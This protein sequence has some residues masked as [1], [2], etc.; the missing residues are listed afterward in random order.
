MT[1]HF[2]SKKKALKDSPSLLKRK[3]S[4][5]ALMVA[6][7]LMSFVL[8]IILG[9]ST[10]VQVNSKIASS[11]KNL[12]TAKQN[13]LFALNLAIGDLQNEMGPD[14][15]ISATASILDEFPETEA[16]DGVNNPYWTGAWNSNDSLGGNLVNQVVSKN[17]AF[18]DGKPSHFRR[19]LISS[20]I[21]DTSMSP[22]DSIA[23]AKNFN[24][25][26]KDAILMVG[27]G[28]V[29]EEATEE[30]SVYVPRQI[31]NKALENENG[32]AYWVGDE[33]VKTRIAGAP[34]EK[35]ETDLEQILNV[36]NAGSPRLNAIDGFA[37]A[38]DISEQSD[39]IL[40][41]GTA[42]F[43]FNEALGGNVDTFKNKFHSLSAFSRGLMVD[44]KHGGIRKDLSLLFASGSLPMDYDEQPI[45]E[46]DS[47]IGPSWNYALRYHNMY[48]RIRND[49]GRNYI[50]VSDFWEDA[51]TD[52]PADQVKYTDIPIP[53][54]ARMQVI[55]S[56]H[57][58]RN[59][60][61]G[62]Y[63]NALE[64]EII[65]ASRRIVELTEPDDWVASDE[66]DASVDEGT[67][68]FG[69]DGTDLNVLNPETS[70]FF[71]MANSDNYPF[72]FDT[73]GALFVNSISIYTDEQFLS[74][75]LPDVFGPLP[76]INGYAKFTSSNQGSE[77]NLPFSVSPFGG[78]EIEIPPQ[79]PGSEY[80]YFS[81]HFDEGSPTGKITIGSL[82]IVDDPIIPESPAKFQSNDEEILHL[83]MT[84][85]FYLWNPYNVEIVM[86]SDPFNRGAYEYFY[87]PPDVQFTFDN[88]T[89]ISLKKFNTFQFGRGAEL[90]AMW[91]SNNEKNRL[92]LGEGFEI[93]AGEF[94]YNTTIPPP[95]SDS[96]ED[97]PYTR[98]QFFDVW[99]INYR[100]VFGDTESKI[101]IGEDPDAF[102]ERLEQMQGFPNDFAPNVANWVE[103]TN[104]DADF[105]R[106]YTGVFSPVLNYNPL[107]SHGAGLNAD[108]SPK[109]SNTRLKKIV[110]Q[111]S[112]FTFGLKLNNQFFAS[113]LS[114]GAGWKVSN[115]DYSTSTAGSNIHPKRLI[116]ALNIDTNDEVNSFDRRSYH[117]SE[118]DLISVGYNDLPYVLH[119]SS[120]EFV[121]IRDA[122][123]IALNVDIRG[124]SESDT[125]GKHA[126]YIDP[127]N[128]YYYDE[129]SEDSSLALSPFRIY[130]REIDRE[131]PII[132]N[133]V[134]ETSSI[135]F[136]TIAGDQ[137]SKC[138]AKELPLIPLLSLTQLDHAPLGRDSE[139][140]A[141]FSGRQRPFDFYNNY[142][143]DSLLGRDNVVLFEGKEERKMAP[144]FNM[145]V[146]N[147]WAH[148]TIPLNNII[149][150]D[151][152]YEGYATDRSYLLNE[153]LF[154][155]YFFTGLA[156]P[157][158]PFQD[159]MQELSDQLSNWIKE[160]SSLP[161]SNYNFT[162]PQSM[163]KME[164]INTISPSNVDTLE[165]FS[166]IAN[167]IEIEG[168]FN[169]N[170]TSVDSWV[171]QLSSLRGKAVLY[172]NSD[173]GAYNI[174]STNTE[175]TPVLSQTIPAEKS[176]EN[177]GGTLDTIIQN[178]WSHYR[179]LED[180]QLLKLA[181]EIVKQIKA[182]G[183]FLSLSQFFNREISERKP[184]N[185]KGAVQSAIDES[186]INLESTKENV[187]S[188]LIVRFERDQGNQDWIDNADFTAPEIFEGGANEG[189]PGYITQA[190]LLRPLCPILTARSDTF[191]IR[192][193]GDFKENGVIKASTWCEA[194]VQR[195][196]D[197]V[198]E[199]ELLKPSYD[200]NEANA[201][202]RKFEIVSFRWLNAD[203]I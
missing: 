45:F 157:S 127:A 4:G 95:Y 9:L 195:R 125:P 5:F 192:A 122:K 54:L 109:E 115:P 134:G 30:N 52:I 196:I 14:Q 53:V 76:P 150:V 176:L 188:A 41:L 88:Q 172:D 152:L 187:Q 44:V 50:N 105:D 82:Q 8:L 56:L 18:S 67:S 180:Q 186:F 123:K 184:Y 193:Y 108:G 38:E 114:L 59:T 58:Q 129:D 121:G 3:S 179:S 39:K 126:F 85:I 102:E 194:V 16:I 49:G 199:K 79:S 198:D 137:I 42:Q 145:A 161:N 154:D 124:F 69:S 20:P 77:I 37:D 91:S 173:Y 146:G 191:I 185:I 175:N 136:E 75:I 24:K 182:R 139:H 90:F 135:M 32:Y 35:I 178:S 89:W 63:N 201:F 65:T 27:S 78:V 132:P 148:P 55:F 174:D 147:S 51:K 6:L 86:D 70:P 118:S 71:T 171:A 81:L 17:R 72:K 98:M 169:I 140:F 23:F 131:N 97:D 33:G 120:N 111:D 43:A 36:N 142:E 80:N 163:S 29:G 160:T 47:A 200:K 116:G 10:L 94:R 25:D 155:S 74:A 189:L 2:F 165:L 101:I 83:M 117:L 92:T 167:F 110:K 13:A 170:S 162:V 60:F 104:D 7:G 22:E 159:D 113:R 12:A 100:S 177:T 128:N 103:S 40:T 106:V 73:G 21:N 64:N 87:A 143:S 166:K 48:K 183:P 26:S 68:Y 11:E 197:L 1:S 164:V 61:N 144:S 28:T 153:K 57:K 168:A 202:N 62:R 151:N 149:E 130:L 156:F 34:P 99:K 96:L 31:I 112:N 93:P 46:Y 190:S 66:N 138:V 141:Y 158:G 84:P 19:W 181:E 15:R 107:E 119:P 203:E 133:P